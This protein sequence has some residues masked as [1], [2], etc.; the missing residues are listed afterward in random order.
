M[1]IAEGIVTLGR[2]WCPVVV[3]E[4]IVRLA[5]DSV[6][7]AIAVT[8]TEVLVETGSLTPCGDRDGEDCASC[9]ICHHVCLF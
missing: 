1:V 8:A 4:A 7:E 9:E 2:L 5:E 6:T 3:A